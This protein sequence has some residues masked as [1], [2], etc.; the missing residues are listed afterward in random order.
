MVVG[1][2]P[3]LEDVAD[4]GLDVLRGEGQAGFADFDG[5][6]LGGADGGEGQGGGEEDV[7]ERR[8]FVCLVCCLCGLR[9]G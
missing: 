6:G 2:E 1:V 4:V 8:H 7:G 5:D 3:E 9:D